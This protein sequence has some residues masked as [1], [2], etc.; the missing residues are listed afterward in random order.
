MI[1]E[2]TAPELARRLAAPNPPILVDVREPNEFQF[3]CI[4]GAQLK[5]LG[6]IMLWAGGLDREA[7]YVVQCHSG[8]RSGQAVGYLQSLGFKRVFNLRGGIDAWS[9][10]VDPNVPRY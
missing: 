10:L 3:C 7:E 8:F 2:I 5:P 6:D 4:E 9:T 1:P